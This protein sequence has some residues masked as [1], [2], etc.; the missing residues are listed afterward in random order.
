MPKLMS[1]LDMLEAQA[2]FALRETAA[3]FE[4]PVLLYSIGKDSSVLLRLATKAFAPA[5]IPFP[6]L[7]VDTGM[8]FKEMYQFRSQIAADPNL[9]LLIE[10]PGPLPDDLSQID[11]SH[12]CAKRKTEALLHALSAHRFDAAIGGA[13]REEEK[14]RAKE[15]MFSYRNRNGVWDPR[16]QRPEIWNVFNTKIAEG[17]SVRVFP[18]S[19]WTEMD[20]WLYIERE[21][22]P[23]VPLYFAA[24]RLVIERNGQLIPTEGCQN[25]LRPGEQMVTR[26][27]RF[28]TLGCFPCTAAVPS[29][30]KTVQE[31]ILELST[32]DGSER[33]TRLIDFDV[34]GSMERKK[35]EGYF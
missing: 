30:A 12:C 18:L 25:L 34:E 6:L 20:I 17:E 2:I 35:K 22:I 3:S 14:S 11:R 5:P 28:R 27:C 9:T 16:R 8:K 32:T 26:L 10:E 7:H 1:H 24:E 31:I 15:R 33:T 19:D 23:V 13:R 21:K 29:T 4:R